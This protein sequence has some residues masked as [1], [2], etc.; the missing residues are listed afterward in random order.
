MDYSTG[1]YG[2]ASTLGMELVEAKSIASDSAAVTFSGLNGDV[3]K[4]YRFYCR[5]KNTNSGAGNLRCR[6]NALATNLYAARINLT[7]AGALTGSGGLTDWIVGGSGTAETNKEYAYDVYIAAATGWRRTFWTAGL[8]QIAAIASTGTQYYSG[9]WNE[10]ATNI[11]SFEW[12]FDAG[13][14][15]SGSQITLWKVRS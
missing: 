9:T 12:S 6:P 15:A 2:A 14:I 7:N 13:N 4:Y 10:T 5:V 3:D 11:T 8:I 1:G